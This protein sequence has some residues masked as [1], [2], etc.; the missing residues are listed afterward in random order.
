MA[1]LKVKQSTANAGK[2]SA[3]WTLA[4]IANQI[5]SFLNDDGVLVAPQMAIHTTAEQF[6]LTTT[7]IITLDGVN[8]AKAP[9]NALTFTANHPVTA[10]RFGSVLVQQTAAGVV[11]TRITGVT[12]TTTQAYTTAT[13]AAA[14]VPAPQA[15]NVAIGYMVIAAGGGGFTANTTALTG[16]TTFYTY[17]KSLPDDIEFRETGKP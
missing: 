11:S 13:A 16:I 2:N 14:A 1:T 8:Y 12:Q 17:Q 10:S 3:V 4:K 9:E 6:A 15:N 7:G 5:A